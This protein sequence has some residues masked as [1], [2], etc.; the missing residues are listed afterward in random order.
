MWSL[1]AVRPWSLDQRSY[2][3]SSTVTVNTWMRDRVWVHFPVPD[4]YLGRLC[5][6]PSRP[7]Q[8]SIFSGSVNEDQAKVMVHSVK[9]MNAGCA[10]KLVRSI[11][12]AC[13]T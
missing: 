3:T 11:E 2:P 7:T 1:V 4:I 12:N 13:Y 9:R 10:G 6:Q 8:P 5:N